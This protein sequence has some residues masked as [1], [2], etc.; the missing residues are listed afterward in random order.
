M[1]DTAHSLTVPLA[2]HVAVARVNMAH[3]NSKRA[4]V[5]RERGV[6]AGLH[7][8]R[9]MG[10]PG[11]PRF[12]ITSHVDGRSTVL[13]LS[14]ELDLATAAQVDEAI[15][16]ARA[17]GNSITVD[18]RPLKFI[19]SSGLRVLLAASLSAREE[20]WSLLVVHGAGN[21][22]RIFETAGVEHL[23]PFVEATG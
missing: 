8:K 14:G 17:A 3:G 7:P 12:E 10:S 2:T 5:M 1:D 23:I 21:V 19:D 18:L 13:A 9:P 16:E 4:R 22:R 6:S 20:G 15:E 11:L